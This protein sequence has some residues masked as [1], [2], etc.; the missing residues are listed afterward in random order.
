MSSQPI[1]NHFEEYDD[2]MQYDK[3]NQQH[4]ADI[5]FLKK[6][7]A[8]TSGPIIDLACGT[9]RATIPLAN[10]GHQLIGVDVHKGMLEAAKKKASPLH[11]SIEWVEQDCSNLRLNVKSRMIYSVGNSFQHFLTNEAQDKLLLS[12]NKHLHIGGIFIFGTR[13]PNAEELLQPETEEY[14]KTY[15]DSDTKQQVDVYTISSYDQLKQLQHYMTIRK[16]ISADGK[17]ANEKKTT[18]TL[19]YVFP[20]EMERLLFANGFEIVDVFKDWTETPLTNDSVEM[21]YV[22]RKGSDL[23]LR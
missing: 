15:T 16:Y 20:K 3:E 14:W 23:P 6:W 22:C 8:K 17:I 18:I 4:T 19:R 13:F 21:I 2:P 10:E 12:V 9:G 7:A 11:V 5:P 1:E